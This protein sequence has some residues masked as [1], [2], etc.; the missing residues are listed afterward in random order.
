M[1]KIEKKF[2]RSEF[3]FDLKVNLRPRVSL[4]HNNI[5]VLLRYTLD[6]LSGKIPSGSRKKEKRLG[7]TLTAKQIAK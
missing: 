1:K 5:D 4:T 7:K 6:T 3:R 2:S